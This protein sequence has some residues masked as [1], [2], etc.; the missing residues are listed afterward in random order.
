MGTAIQKR[1]LHFKCSWFYF[2]MYSWVIHVLTS[3]AS[4]NET[5]IWVSASL[6]HIPLH[7]TWPTFVPIFIPR[8]ALCHILAIACIAPYLADHGIYPDNKVYGANMGPIWGR[9]DPDGPHVGPM[10]FAIWVVNGD[11]HIHVQSDRID[12]HNSI[13][14]GIKSSQAS[15]LYTAVW[16]N[17][18]AKYYVLKDIQNMNV[19]VCCNFAKY[20][21]KCSMSC[22]PKV[23]E[24]FHL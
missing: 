9:Q 6:S 8:I 2:F 19:S 5:L 10:N 7:A 14:I 24:I 17:L 18:K 3:N 23:N 16:L 4:C 11:R 15:Q 1:E 13:S 22:R 20:L 12:L 21:I